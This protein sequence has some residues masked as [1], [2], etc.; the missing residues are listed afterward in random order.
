MSRDKIR[1]RIVSNNPLGGTA[2]Q[3]NLALKE[4]KL[5]PVLAKTDS[6][7]L[8][9]SDKSKLLTM[10]AETDK[11]I[12]LPNNN[13]EAIPVGFRILCDQLG[14]GK[15]VFVPAAGVTL[16]S[17]QNGD[18]TA[19]QFARGHLHKVATNTWWL[20]G[21]LTL[22]GYLAITANTTP[23][24]ESTL[25]GAYIMLT[26]TNTV[27]TMSPTPGNYTLNNAPAGVSIA[28]VSYISPTQVMLTLDYDGTD[29]DVDATDISVTV[30]GA[31]MGVANPLTTNSIAASALVESLAAAPSNP[32]SLNEGN[33]DGAIIL[34]TVTN[35][36][37]MPSLVA[38]NFSLVNAPTG[39]TIST[40]NR[41]S[42]TQAE[43]TL[44]FADGNDFDTSVTAFKVTALGTA[45]SRGNALTSGNMTITALIEALLAV[46]S[47][48]TSLSE[49][50]LNGAE[51]ALTIT[52]EQFA[53]GTLT[54]ANFTLN[55]APTGLTVASVLWV[56]ATQAVVTLAF[57]GTDFDTDYT[58]FRIVV[59]AT[60]LTRQV[61]LTSNAMTI[62]AVIETETLLLEIF[63]QDGLDGM[64]AYNFPVDW[65]VSGEPDQFVVEDGDNNTGQCDVAGSSAEQVLAFYH[66]STNSSSVKT[67]PISTI[68]KSN[69]KVRWNEINT[70]FSGNQFTL[71]WSTNGSTWFNV[72]LPTIPSDFVWHQRAFVSL[73]AGANNQ[74][75]LYF[76]LTKVGDGIASVDGIDDF[77]VTAG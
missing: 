59:A 73:P 72:T 68:G 8:T 3:A 63:G 55:N 77:Q 2:T 44:A 65:V 56:S 58:N 53:D 60:E 39:V 62:T 37:F 26:V 32:T 14:T 31:E 52:N 6:Y 29:F 69:I 15:I 19:G 24:D 33:I 50:N 47:S 12:T 17:Y 25:D 27:F 4:D 23:F 40:V 22:T 46:P 74:A 45:L 1:K 11:I 57:D 75:T 21:E 36:T 41:L 67:A 64:G 13:D 16:T 42:D 35:E 7:T 9:A 48:V 34:V 54:T 76:R 10:D 61:A 51:I 18:S 20:N 43:I 66:N 38:G 49:T 5:L 71:E 30:A 28:N 70:N